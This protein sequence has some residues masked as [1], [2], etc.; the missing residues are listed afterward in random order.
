MTVG[1]GLL[2]RLLY[3]ERTRFRVLIEKGVTEELFDLPEERAAFLYIKKHVRQYGR[4]PAPEVLGLETALDLPHVIPDE[5]LEFW[6]DELFQL[7]ALRTMQ[8]HLDAAAGHVR[9]RNLGSAIDCIRQ[10]YRKQLEL[11]GAGSI[12]SLAA[13]TG[14]VMEEHRRNQ[15]LYISGILPGI[16]FGLPFIDRVTGGAQPG[17]SVVLAARTSVGK[18]YLLLHWAISAFLAGHRILLISM[19]MT[20]VQIARRILGI[21]GSI[22][23]RDLRFG[24]LSRY[25]SQA[26]QERIDALL[27]G[28]D[29][30]GF[31]VVEGGMRRSYEDV[32][33]LMQEYKPNATYIDGAYL[34]KGGNETKSMQGWERQAHITETLKAIAIDQKMPVIQTHQFSKGGDKDGAEGV[35]RSKAIAEAASLFFRLSHEG[36]RAADALYGRVMY[37]VLDIPKGREGEA[38][39]VRLRFDLQRGAI[40]ED[41]VILGETEPEYEPE[42][43]T[44]GGDGGQDPVYG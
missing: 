43:E 16:P 44:H 22:N 10:A 13:L 7:Y 37:R 28:R 27:K 8:K 9:D 2:A 29:P 6:I 20:K 33:L 14:P 4:A 32:L 3:S 38:G 21:L 24:Y 41:E 39:C 11:G 5:P 17:D 40:Y 36:T 15:Q 12:A 18:T 1:Q 23:P 42:Y 31:V 30:D 34:L 19:E 35:G 26:L 25:G